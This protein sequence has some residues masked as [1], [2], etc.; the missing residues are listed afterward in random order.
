LQKATADI[1]KDLHRSFC[2]H[3]LYQTEA[4]INALRNVLRAYAARN[5]QVNLCWRVFALFAKALYFNTGG[6]RTRDEHDL[7]VVVGVYDRGRVFLATQHHCGGVSAR[8]LSQDFTGCNSRARDVWTYLGT[9]ITTTNAA[10]H[11]VRL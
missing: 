10:L 4:G 11:N 1:E 8:V 9:C 7:F 3:P 5:P 2:E 6:I